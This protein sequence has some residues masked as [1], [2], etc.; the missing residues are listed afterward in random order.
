[1]YAPSGPGGKS[2][3]YGGAPGQEEAVGCK[4]RHLLHTGILSLEGSRIVL[5]LPSCVGKGGGGREAG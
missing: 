5:L 1:M 2:V 4:P 3:V